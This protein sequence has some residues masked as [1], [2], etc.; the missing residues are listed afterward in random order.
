MGRQPEA[1]TEHRKEVGK[2]LSALLRAEGMTTSALAKA[3]HLDRT[4]ISHVCAGR[5]FPERSFWTTADRALEANGLL[6]ASY[7]RA[8]EVERTEKRMQLE[9]E[10][11]RSRDEGSLRADPL[12]IAHEWLV[13]DSPGII[14]QNSGRRIGVSLVGKFEERVIELRHLDDVVFGDDLY[15]A[16]RK[17]LSDV[18]RVVRSASYSAST[19]KRLLVVLGELAQLAGWV[20]S[21]SGRHTEAQQLYLDGAAATREARDRVLTAQLLSSLSYQMANTGSAADAALLAKSAVKG[22]DGATPLVKALLLERVAW[23]NA[24]TRDRDS[25]MRALGAVDDAYESRSK[26]IREPEWVYW[27]NR[28]EIDVMAGRCMIEIGRPSEAEPLLSK[29]ID[30][31]ESKHVRE[32]ALYLSWLAEAYAKAGEMDAA[33]ETLNRA[34]LTGKGVKS[35]RLDARINQVELL[36]SATR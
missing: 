33:D 16:I 28:E 14:H 29:A 12:R 34:K 35:K 27:L 30:A 6:V 15:P 7:D 18:E 23:A 36:A 22:A 5:Q 24:R 11:A 9:N 20:A 13:T 32:V 10:L 19:G 3:T 17:E 4:S 21:D 31:Y 2:L 25:T 1:I 26:D 8:A